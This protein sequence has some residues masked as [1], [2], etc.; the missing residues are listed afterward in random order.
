L[1]KV[2]PKVTAIEGIEDTISL[3]TGETLTVEPVLKPEKFADEPVT[4]TTADPSVAE[5]KSD[6]NLKA[7]S[8]GKTTLTVSA[9]GSSFESDITVTDPVIYVPKKSGSSKSSSGTSQS[10]SSKSGSGKASKG[11]FDSGDDE[12]F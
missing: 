4:Y 6:G 7:V 8:A 1:I 11:Y 2:V 10:S 9:G 5:V 3:T 12:E